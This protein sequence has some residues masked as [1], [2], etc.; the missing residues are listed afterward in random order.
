M[1]DIALYHQPQSPNLAR[2]AYHYNR[3]PEEVRASSSMAPAKRK[4]YST[5]VTS[6]PAR[7]PRRE[8]SNTISTAD[9]VSSTSALGIHENE[10]GA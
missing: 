3:A 8:T 9:Q 1:G 7:P 10:V 6:V 2:F 4:R 5:P